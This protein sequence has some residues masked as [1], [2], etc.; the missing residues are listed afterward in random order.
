MLNSNIAQGKANIYI[1]STPSYLPSTLFI[2]PL[3][4]RL[5]FEYGF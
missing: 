1:N 4:H 5:I 2:S 3:S